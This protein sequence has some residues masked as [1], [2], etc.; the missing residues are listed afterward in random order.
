[1]IATLK[2]EITIPRSIR[3]QAGVKLGQ[4]V[5]FEVLGS[6]I[7]IVPVDDEKDDEY[8]PA[9]RRA[10]DRDIAQSQ[11][12]FAEGKGFGPFNT[13]EELMASLNSKIP[14]RKSKTRRR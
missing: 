7:Q 6:I 8:T 5:K 14:R 1:M 9:Q 4:R 13:V 12:E 3:R 2:S 10:I 11:K